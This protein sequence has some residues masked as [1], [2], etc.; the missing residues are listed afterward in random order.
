M[1][2]PSPTTG[3]MVYRELVIGQLDEVHSVDLDELVEGLGVTKAAGGTVYVL[4]NG[5]SQANAAHL[6]LH[7]RDKGYRAI[8][9]LG[10]LPYLTASANDYGYE[11]VASRM[12]RQHCAGPPDTLFVISG[13]GNS[14]NV[15]RALDTAGAHGVRRLGLLGFGGGEAAKFIGGVVLPSTNYGAVEDVHSAIIHYLATVL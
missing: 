8:D 5:G 14:P 10:D 2:N 1:A 3:W 11:G 6:V 15:L 13:S 7:L 9:M 4:G 12:L